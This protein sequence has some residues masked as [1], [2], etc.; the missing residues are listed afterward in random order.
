MKC[1]K[2][3]KKGKR[4]KQ[5]AITDNEYCHIHLSKTSSKE[6]C[7]IC[8]ESDGVYTLDCNHH[9]HLKCAINMVDNR[10]PLCREPMKNIPTEIADTIEKNKEKFKKERE[11]ELFQQFVRENNP[12]I[13]I[14]RINAAIRMALIELHNRGVPQRFIPTDVRI[15]TFGNCMNVCPSKVYTSVMV[16]SFEL[17]KDEIGEDLDD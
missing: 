11:E 17:M 12:S 4:C 16:K 5:N 10:C 2:Y 1:K 3:T 15:Q 8:L 14:S 9:L 6:D 7:C 13:F